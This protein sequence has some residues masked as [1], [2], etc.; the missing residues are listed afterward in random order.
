M[1]LSIYLF[2][3]QEITPQEEQYEPVPDR[4]NNI[5]D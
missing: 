1:V 4:S 2:N 3:L 5:I